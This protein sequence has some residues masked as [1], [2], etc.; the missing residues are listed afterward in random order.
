MPWERCRWRRAGREVQGAVLLRPRFPGLE[1]AYGVA[2]SAAATFRKPPRRPVQQGGCTAG[3]CATNHGR[4]MS[5][6]GSSK[7]MILRGSA[8]QEYWFEEGCFITEWLN[9]PDDPSLSIARARVTPGVTTRL[10]RLE[11]DGR[12][13]P[14]PRRP[15]AGGTGRARRDLDQCRPL[16]VGC[17]AGRCRGDPAAGVAADQQHRRDRPGLPRALH[18]PLHS[19][20]LRGYGG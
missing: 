16:R 4:F 20:S 14:D 9:T 5:N 2:A 18:A 6:G 19:A 12:A 15:G 1:F 11:G 3:R 13:L 8:T 7:P 17:R 10:H